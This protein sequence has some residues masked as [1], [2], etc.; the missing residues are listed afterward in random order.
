M[1]NDN[2]MMGGHGCAFRIEQSLGRLQIFAKLLGTFQDWLAGW[3]EKKPGLVMPENLRIRAEIVG[4][5][6][7]RE[8]RRNKSMNKQDRNLIG[9]IRMNQIN[10]GR[11]PRIIGPQ[12]RSSSAASYLSRMRI[13]Y[14]QSRSIVGCNRVR[15]GGGSDYGWIESVIQFQQRYLTWALFF[16]RGQ[17]KGNAS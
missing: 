16:Y 5:I 6:L 9:V 8:W 12:E 7:P 14:R 13:Q 2:N 17:A 3:I 4:Q 11:E 1:S 10:A 15:P